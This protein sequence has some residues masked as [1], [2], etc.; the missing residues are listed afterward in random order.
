MIGSVGE[1]MLE[2]AIPYVQSWNVWY[3]DTGNSP[4]G[5]APLR[6]RVDAACAKA[7]RDPASVGATVVVLVRMAGGA[8]RRNGDGRVDS[9]SIPLAGSP[10]L[11]AE[12]LRAY[13]RAGVEEVQL[14]VD[15]ITL[16]SLEGVAAAL[17]I[18]DRG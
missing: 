12:G 8:G 17:E 11:I 9:A 7:G 6:A 2:I 4:A 14:V 18:L 1:R 15:P 13:A 3:T 5:V 16:E 10:E